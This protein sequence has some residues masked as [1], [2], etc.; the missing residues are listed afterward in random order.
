[1]IS[2]ETD[3]GLE[4]EKSGPCA[5]PQVT[6][7]KYQERESGLSD[8]IFQVVLILLGVLAF[9]RKAKVVYPPTP[10]QPHTWAEWEIS[11][12]AQQL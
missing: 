4:M 1:M 10:M 7:L 12:C 5:G 3:P 9:P 11:C 2:L 6:L 8:E